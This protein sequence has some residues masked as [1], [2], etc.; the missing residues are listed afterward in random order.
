M[1]TTGV[2]NIP[3]FGLLF[4]FGTPYYA[5]HFALYYVLHY[6]LLYTVHYAIHFAIHYAL[7]F[8]L[9]YALHSTLHY[10]LHNQCIINNCWRSVPLPCGQY[11]AIFSSVRTSNS[12]PDL[13]MTHPLFQIKHVCH[14]ITL[15]FTF[16]ATTAISKAITDDDILASFWLHFG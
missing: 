7:H 3:N 16:W 10:S 9:H 13:L 6:T 11:M 5:L 4:F 12:H 2:S 8:A 15:T 1:K 14:Y